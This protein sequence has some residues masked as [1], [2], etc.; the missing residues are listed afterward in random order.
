MSK[1]IADKWRTVDAETRHYCEMIADD[2]LERHKQEVAKFKRMYGEEAFKAA[3]SS[4]KKTCHRRSSKR[5]TENESSHTVSNNGEDV[6]SAM[7]ETN[8]NAQGERLSDYLPDD[9]MA[10]LALVDNNE[11]NILSGDELDKMFESDDDSFY[12]LTEV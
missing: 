1:V 3:T 4:R 6:D 12:N 2:E 7:I 5:K 9:T 10:A 11:D 8:T